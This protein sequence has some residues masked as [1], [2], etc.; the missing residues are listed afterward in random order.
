MGTFN[1]H[2]VMPLYNAKKVLPRLK[3]MVEILFTPTIVMER[4][5]LVTQLHTQKD[6]VNQGL[7]SG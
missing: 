2:V 6:T 7:C 4:E 1:V 3:P 5:L